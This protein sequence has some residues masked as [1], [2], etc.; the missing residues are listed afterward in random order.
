MTRM[1]MER[2]SLV[3]VVPSDMRFL[4]S[5][6]NT[7]PMQS[8]AFSERNTDYKDLAGPRVLVQCLE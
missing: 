7:P 3:Q 4:L 2:T 5:F 1:L 6:H 8:E